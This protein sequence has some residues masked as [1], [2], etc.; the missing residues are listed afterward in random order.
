[1]LSRI[2]WTYNTGFYCDFTRSRYPVVC[3]LLTLPLLL[4]LVVARTGAD[5]TR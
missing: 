5:D 1:M 3:L 4:L 2:C